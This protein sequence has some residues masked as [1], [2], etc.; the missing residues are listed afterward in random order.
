[1]ADLNFTIGLSADGLIQGAAQAQR[2][3]DGMDKRAQALGR[4]MQQQQI[5]MEQGAD[6]LRLYKIASANVSES[7]KKRLLQMELATQAAAKERAAQQER[8]AGVAQLQAAWARE[9]AAQNAKKQAVDKSI[10]AMQKEAA[11]LGKTAAA[12]RIAGT[13]R[14]AGA[15]E[16]GGSF[17]GTDCRAATFEPR[18]RYRRQFGRSGFGGGWYRRH[19]GHTESGGRVDGVSKPLEAGHRNYRRT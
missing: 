3:L 14:N 7:D 17:A 11:V 13:G 2:A 4:Q 9:E 6:A 15:A 5:L 12:V 10:A 8:A 1:M 16:T 18:G 19:G